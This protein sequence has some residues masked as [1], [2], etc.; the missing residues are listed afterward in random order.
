[1]LAATDVTV[2]TGVK[3]TP[4]VTGKFGSKAGAAVTG[5]L[6]S[7]AGA[8]VSGTLGIK[9]G[10]AWLGGITASFVV[11]VVVVGCSIEVE[12]G[13]LLPPDP[14]EGKQVLGSW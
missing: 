11:V 13:A 6:G 7:K 1:M 2:T 10:A 5:K 9:A 4:A 3:A 12:G 14:G 8:A